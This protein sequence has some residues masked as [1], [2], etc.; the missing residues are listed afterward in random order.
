P[1]AVKKQKDE[2]AARESGTERRY[3]WDY[4]E[5]YELYEYD[6][7]SKQYRQ[8]TDAKGYDAEGCYSPD[9]KLVV[10]ASNRRGYS[11]SLDPKTAGIFQRDPSVMSDIFIM[12]V[13]GTGLKQ[14]TS[15][16]GYDGGPFFSH[17]GKKICYRHFDESGAVAEIFTMNLDGSDKKQLTRLGAMSWAPFFHPSG[18]YLVFATNRHG[19]SNFELYLVDAAGKSEPVRVTATDGFDGLASFSPDGNTLTWT[20]NRTSNNSSQIFVAKWNHE[21][22]RK[23]LGIDASAV[24]AIDPEA[25]ELAQTNAAETTADFRELDL[26]K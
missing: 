4:D 1:E 5:T 12:N 20:S 3:A 14:L 11:E 8:L 10:F 13:D 2:L 15:E 24:T 19:F 9:G 26:M 25:Q 7:A 17:D 22:A 18:E 6:L 16:P 21:A 23:A